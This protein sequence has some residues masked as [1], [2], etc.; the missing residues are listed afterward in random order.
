MKYCLWLLILSLSFFSS[1]KK[2]KDDS[3]LMRSVKCIEAEQVETLVKS[4][5]FPGRVKAASDVSLS[6]RVSGPILKRYSKE[7]T[8]V[9]KGTLIAEIDPRDYHTQ[10]NATKAEHQSIK[11]EA[12][13][14]IELY[15]RNSAT[16]ND[17]DKAV[18]GL[19]QINAKLEAHTNA[20]KDTKLYAPFDGY[21]DKVYFDTDETVSAGMPIVSMVATSNPE[22]EINIPSSEYLRMNKY[23]SAS[24]RIDVYPDKIFE[25]E[26]VGASPKANLNQLYN[27]RFRINQSAGVMPTPGMTTMVTICYSIDD[28]EKYRIPATSVFENDGKTYVWI[29]S[30]KTE[31]VTLRKVDIAEISTDGNVLISD[32]LNCG[33]VVVCAGVKSL[34]DG[35]RVKRLAQSSAS[36]VGGIL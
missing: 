7:G 29:Y 35:Q 28:N 6:F 34:K 33:D 25:L 13:R 27:T 8:Y 3:D 15:K 24:C 36:N 17:Y 22:V 14:I 2:K 12:D 10:L 19:K 18:N 30:D 11:S 26:L 16:Q 32:G 20:L 23:I 21:I 9:K 5:S 31:S 1:C 4:Y